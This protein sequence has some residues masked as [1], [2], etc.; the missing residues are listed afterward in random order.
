MN[1]SL[2]SN[3]TQED[4]KDIAVSRTSSVRFICA[5]IIM[6]V[7]IISVT[8][9]ALVLVMV[10]KKRRIAIERE[11]NE[12][13]GTYDNGPEYNIVTDENMYYQ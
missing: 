10:K 3:H 1:Q 2:A 7:V 8:V 4:A 11:R 9:I 5:N 13:Y 6:A 12:L